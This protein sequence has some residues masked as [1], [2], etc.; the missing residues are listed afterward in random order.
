MQTATV[1]YIILAGI[2]AL[3]IAL[4]QY[5]YKSKKRKL[6]P[7]FALLR[8]VTIFAI[9]LLIV[10]PKFEKITL[11][12]EKP[13]LLV[14][15]D[16]S[17]SI[18]FLEQVDDVNNLVNTIENSEAL[19]DKFDVAYYSF[20]DDF[21]VLDSLSFE[22]SQT[23]IATVFNNL[24]QIYK[25]TNAPT[26]VITDGNQTYGNDYEF[27]SNTYSQPLFP[28]ILGDTI[29]YSDIRIQQLNVNKYAY[30]KNKFPVE[31][32]VVYNGSSNITSQ[33]T[34]SSGNSVIH[35]ETIEFSNTNNSKTVTVTIPANKVGVTTYNATIA[36]I[37]N[38]KNTTN[39]S[40][41]F[42]VDVIDQK[43][44]I[45]I[46]STISHPDIGV[47]RKAIESNEH[48]SVDILSPNEYLDNKDDY[49]MVILYQPNSS[50]RSVF[51]AL[52]QESKN[53]FIVTGPQTD[54]M[55]LNNIQSVYQQEITGQLEDYQAVLNDNFGT[56]IINELNVSNF[57]PLRSEF[58]SI[59]FDKPFETLLY[60]QINGTIIQE[61]LMVTFEEL[62]RREAV[63]FGE[64]L[65]R[66][67][68]Q[69]YLDN[70][71]FEVFDDFMSKIVQY[72]A[73]N[74]RRSRLNIEYESFYNGN[75]NV[76]IQAQFFN[77]NY[78]FD[79]RASLNITL[80]NIKTNTATTIPFVLKQNNYEVDISSLDPGTYKFTVSANNGELSQTGELTILDYSVEK[81]FLN[82]NVT[83]LQEVATNSQGTAYF[84]SQTEALINDLVN[85][86]RFATIQKSSKNVV[87]LI[88]FKFLLALIALS[89]AIEWFLR[90]Y[91]GLI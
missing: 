60:K 76:K 49:Q 38:E 90:K 70:R 11:T 74:K 1:L 42:A 16:D 20:G 25:N 45:A 48:R 54:F 3:L 23:N 9:L 22:S 78:E 47:L 44:N 83:K 5:I 17:Q 66:W 31:I 43:T 75:N 41:P 62:G 6:N 85:D 65:W 24:E 36:P 40:K 29:S 88:D 89:L 4:F 28:V 50:F 63:L 68:A 35:R 53:R 87:P 59:E 69:N 12:N 82:A 56:F 72:I 58:G 91:N 46:V 86:S 18:S 34:V 14:A 30:L 32:I 10:N 55:F 21:E 13:K 57:P 61:P 51:D 71:T 79:G 8:F 64:G 37:D 52:D 27:V 15:I 39:N 81:Q 67:R 73:S 33:L 7:V 84:T 2:A 80:T 26:I 77:K 19:N